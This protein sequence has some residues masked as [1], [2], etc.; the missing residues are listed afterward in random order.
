MSA[1]EAE[2]RLSLPEDLIP[3]EGGPQELQLK[4]RH[5]WAA[6]AGAVYW[7]ER[8]MCTGE[9]LMFQEW[10]YARNHLR[11]QG[12]QVAVLIGRL[13]HTRIS[14]RRPRARTT[15]ILDRC[16]FASLLRP[17]SHARAPGWLQN[18]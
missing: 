9:Q 2:S 18:E 12:N 16:P 13:Q 4:K 7:K 11:M 6:A 17:P 3:G 14:R 1:N 8:L 15:E 5:E 10:V